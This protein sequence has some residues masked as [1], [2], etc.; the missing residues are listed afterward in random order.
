MD[1]EIFLNGKFLDSYDDSITIRNILEIAEEN[2][3]LIQATIYLDN[4]L[5]VYLKSI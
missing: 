2:N 5:N 4:I 1:T 3:S